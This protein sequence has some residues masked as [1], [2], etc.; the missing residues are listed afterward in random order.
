MSETRYLRIF[1]AC[2]FLAAGNLD[3]Q[4]V[5]IPDAVSKVS[6]Y[7]DVFDYYGKV[8]GLFSSHNTCLAKGYS[9]SL[10][11]SVAAYCAI[12]DLPL[13]GVAGGF[14]DAFQLTQLFKT[15]CGNG[16]CFACC[17]V[18]GGRFPC[19]TS[20]F[21]EDGSPVINC[22]DG[23][24]PGTHQV[25]PTLITDPNAKP[26]QACLFTPQTCDHLPICSSGLS[27]QEIAAINADPQNIM[28]SPAA[29]NSRARSFGTATL[30][31]W[32]NFLSD[33]RTSTDVQSDFVRQQ[34]RPFSA[35]GS[36]VTGRGCVGWR[37]KIPDS[38]PSDWSESQFRINDAA[39]MYA[40]EP[41]HLNGMR[42]LGLVRLMGTIPNLF[43]R[44]AFVESQIWSPDAIHQ[45][46]AKIGD[47][48]TAFLQHMSPIALAILK[49]N[50]T[51][52]DY[53]LLAVPLAGET[54]SPRLFNG[55]VLGDPPALALTSQKRGA[56]GI[57]LAL[58]AADSAQSTGL[59]VGL[60]VLWGDGSETRITVPPGGHSQAV[61]HD[62]AAGGKYQVLAIAQNDAGLRAVG[63]LVA[64]TAGTGTNPAGVAM[65]VISEIQL[66][67]LHA[68]IDSFA[69]NTLTMMFQLESWPTPDQ[70]YALGVS[71]S[72]PVPLTTAV[73]FGTVAGWNAQSAP[74]QSVTIRPF[75]FG[76]G[77]LI[78][79]RE[80]Y[81]TLDRVR[82]GVYST[83]D[84]HQRYQDIPVKA[85]MVRL[86]P[87]G[88]KVAVLLSKPT[89][90]SDGR[91]KIPVEAG[92]VRYER[93]DLLF[94]PSVFV[95]AV[96]APVTDANW[97]GIVG[98][99]VEL[100][101]ADGDPINLR[102][103]AVVNH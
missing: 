27:P 12:N 28:K 54:V 60:L 90:G 2:I 22:D 42:Q 101:P 9:S 40:A 35:L 78:G 7:K 71:R 83:Q 26:G 18:P 34:I 55:C 14:I 45:Y 80:N 41:S 72:L 51:L 67:D 89:F 57:D 33:Y 17:Y 43:N 103:R 95:N 15:D 32:S 100:K 1:A 66:V 13:G 93:V 3:G 61:S 46:L 82:I 94:P 74:L 96:Q 86:Y 25:G 21:S 92:G 5:S 85:E 50:R 75:R 65:P 73:G 64:E 23:Y 47:P 79:F 49:E 16:I 31:N 19:H 69:G 10:C 20:F 36:F 52:Q 68:E 87:V 98:S 81:L 63:A 59:E 38:F 8:P 56:L 53:R 58:V 70:G 88:S 44:L 37:H 48:D 76:D 97:S 39:G 102:R 91:L 11:A 4:V 99:F 84:N 30:A 24:G 62:Y 6:D 29:V 77:V